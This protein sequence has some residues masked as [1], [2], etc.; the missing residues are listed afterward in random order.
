MSSYGHGV[1]WATLLRR[2]GALIG[3]GKGARF[4][5]R[6]FLDGG[7][8]FRFRSMVSGRGKSCGGRGCVAKETEMGGVVGWGGWG[9][10]G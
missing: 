5:L 3:Q 2:G 6:V 9:L 10:G 4:M 8:S 1:Q 7:S